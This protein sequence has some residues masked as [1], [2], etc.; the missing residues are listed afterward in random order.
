VG[1]YTGA[2]GKRK[3]YCVSLPEIDQ[4]ELAL[5]SFGVTVEDALSVDLGLIES[6]CCR[7]A[8]LRGVFLACGTMS[9]PDKA[10]HM[11]F[12]LHSKQLCRE[13]RKILQKCGINCG[14][15]ERRSGYCVYIKEGES[16][17]N[18]LALSGAGD[19]YYEFV[20]LRIH[21]DLMNITNR[22]VNCD[23]ANIAKTISAAQQQIAAIRRIEESCGLD[24][25][26]QDLRELAELR[27]ENPE[28]TLRDLGENLSVPLS[29]SGVNHRMQRITEIA[30]QLEGKE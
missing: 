24:N 28:M 7:D 5:A 8:F 18:F 13:L 19:A 14:I 12:T 26:P 23:N 30:S 20:N 10:Y 9:D 17:E 22:K 16:I 21:R 29:R 2:E 3:I 1:S 11:D 6:E 25:L 27:I 4:R 15:S